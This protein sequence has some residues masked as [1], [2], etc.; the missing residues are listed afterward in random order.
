MTHLPVL[1]GVLE[2]P[3][4][5]EDLV[6]GPTD[7]EV[8]GGGVPEHA[9]VVHHEGGAHRVPALLQVDAVVPTDGARGVRQ[10]RDFQPG[11]DAD[12]D[13]EAES[14]LAAGHAC[15]RQ[16][17]KVRVHRAGHNLGGRRIK[18]ERRWWGF[19]WHNPRYRHVFF[20]RSQAG[21]R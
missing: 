1:V 9:A 18:R 19:F 12:A 8:A 15:P 2:G 3:D 17:G 20:F 6:D 10:Q 13:A 14:A 21:E 4:Q 16:V 7:V 11:P 5:P